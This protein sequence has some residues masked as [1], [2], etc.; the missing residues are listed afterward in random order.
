MKIK[1]KTPNM[2]RNLAIFLYCLQAFLIVSPCYSVTNE[3]AFS[4]Q[5]VSNFLILY[6]GDRYISRCDLREEQHKELL[7]VYCK[8]LKLPGIKSP[9]PREVRSFGDS[10]FPKV[11]LFLLSWTTKEDQPALCI[12]NKTKLNESKHTEDLGV[13]G[14]FHK[15]QISYSKN[16]KECMKSPALDHLFWELT[17]TEKM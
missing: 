14:D 9:D 1:V 5:A 11:P 3:G 10:Y 16:M 8:T 6:C 12:R 4:L 2:F 13:P 17:G 15:I 7:L